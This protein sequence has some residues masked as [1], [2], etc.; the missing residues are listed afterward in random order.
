M[1]SSY[2]KYSKKRNRYEEPKA[3]KK[4]KCGGDVEAVE[5]QQ[6]VSERQEQQ[7]DAI[8]DNLKF[9]N[10]CRTENTIQNLATEGVLP[11]IWPNK[12]VGG[13]EYIFGFRLVALPVYGGT[14]YGDLTLV[15]RQ[16]SDVVVVSAWSRVMDQMSSLGICN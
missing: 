9:S 6:P 4:V 3:N 1:K 2:N 15:F 11:A 10:F 5:Q 16:D 14:P 12:Y 13:F 7:Q 8:P